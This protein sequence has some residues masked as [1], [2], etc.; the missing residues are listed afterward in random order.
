MTSQTS[1]TAI[2]EKTFKVFASMSI[3]FHPYKSSWFHR[4][5]IVISFLLDLWGEEYINPLRILDFLLEGES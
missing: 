5:D 3:Y 1:K 2:P 4:I